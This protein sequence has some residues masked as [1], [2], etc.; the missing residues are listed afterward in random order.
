MVSKVAT[1][2][3]FAS[4]VGFESQGFVQRFVILFLDSGTIDCLQPAKDGECN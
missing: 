3:L 2:Y 4:L 1:I